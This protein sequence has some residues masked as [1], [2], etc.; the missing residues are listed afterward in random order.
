L[1]PAKPDRAA[2]DTSLN[3]IGRGFGF[4]WESFA[5]IPLFPYKAN[6]MN[7]I[8][9]GFWYSWLKLLIGKKPFLLQIT[10]IVDN[11][12]LFVTRI[13]LF[14]YGTRRCCSQLTRHLNLNLRSKWD[15]GGENSTYSSVFLR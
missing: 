15:P 11:L 4:G 8:G 6:L 5:F 3:R 14:D 13:P 7:R 12:A 10:S 1:P 2:S 9:R